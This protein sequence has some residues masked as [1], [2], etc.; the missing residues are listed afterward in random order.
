[1][2]MYKKNYDGDSFIIVICIYKNTKLSCYV[3]NPTEHQ[4]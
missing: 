3:Y 2:Y 1:M 4:K